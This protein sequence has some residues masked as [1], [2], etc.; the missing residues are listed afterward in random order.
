VHPNPRLA[1]AV[2]HVDMVK[3]VAINSA[4]HSTADEIDG[5]A[6]RPLPDGPW[7]PI[8]CES[9]NDVNS[10]RGAVRDAASVV[11]S[12]S[13]IAKQ[14]RDCAAA[15]VNIALAACEADLRWSYETATV[16]APAPVDS[17]D[18][19]AGTTRPGPNDR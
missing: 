11:Q 8:G 19:A 13:L 9:S 6:N 12:A 17:T 16:A 14:L 5:A 7:A 4:L 3:V 2:I 18:P 10:L 15:A 1:V